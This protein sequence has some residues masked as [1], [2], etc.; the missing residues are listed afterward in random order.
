MVDTITMSKA[1]FT[2]AL[3]EAFINAHSRTDGFDNL[4]QSA[5]SAASSLDQVGKKGAGV[6]NFLDNADRQARK[7]T[8]I[9][10]NRRGNFMT[11]LDTL[12][13]DRAQSLK[14]PFQQAQQSMVGA[15]EMGQAGVIL[16]DLQS[17]G[18][19]AA[20]LN[21]SQEELSDFA[22]QSIDDLRATGVI[23]NEAINDLLRIRNQ[24]NEET[25]GV[26]TF[27]ALGI[28]VNE[29]VQYSSD[30]AGLYG[31][32]M[33][34]NYEGMN[35]ALQENIRRQTLLAQTTGMSVSEQMKATEAIMK[36]PGALARQM[37]LITNP[38]MTQAL[39]GF[40]NTVAAIGAS[41]LAE[42]FISGVGLPTPGNEIEAALKPMTT[43]LLGEINAATARGDEEAV[44]RLSA[45]LQVVYARESQGVMQELGRFA[46][47]L[48]AEFGF[49]QKDLD[50][51][52]ATMLGVASNQNFVG[53]QMAQAQ[54]QIET[55]LNDEALKALASLERTNADLSTQLLKAV[56]KT[57]GVGADDGEGVVLTAVKGANVLTQVAADLTQSL[58]QMISGDL[59]T[60]RVQ[61]A[62]ISAG[63]AVIN[64]QGK[65]E[66]GTATDQDLETLAKLNIFLDQVENLIKGGE[67]TEEFL[68]AQEDLK[69]L[70]NE[71]NKK[72]QTEQQQEYQA[73]DPGVT[74]Q[75]GGLWPSAGQMIKHI[76]PFDG[77]KNTPS[78]AP[79][80]NQQSALIPS[81][82]E[83]NNSKLDIM[84]DQL[85]KLT[86][87]T[88]AAGA[89]TARAIDKNATFQGIEQRIT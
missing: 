26:E 55:R 78:S 87:A 54:T 86:G 66:A 89:M 52:R 35:E 81:L 17:V 34:G 73:G 53:N 63:N 39:V 75:G 65:V 1:D 40:S 46:P 69:P 33:R 49:L 82:L 58:N 20:K 14:F 28:A 50:R 37:D 22:R 72:W 29:I 23:G 57:Y 6:L 47:Y 88:G 42:G 21:L 31:P 5:N 27:R 10:Q 77:G 59:A 74:N 7:A 80:D 16:R 60:I 70:L 76:N 43:A 83:S 4:N 3:T 24:I 38:K 41:D 32:A 15:G 68:A 25:M 19:T 9:A 36:T 45:E 84:N 11:N 61:A 44:R 2:E 71:L 56:N 51:Q 64:I 79:T 62:E 85:I 30:F 67:V 13:G 48:G 12:I 18:D 8:H